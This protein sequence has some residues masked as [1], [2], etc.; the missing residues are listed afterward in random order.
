M[1]KTAINVTQAYEMIE[2]GEAVIVDVREPHEFEAGHIANAMSIP[3]S[4]FENAIKQVHV[5]ADKA[6]LF[7][8]QKGRRSDMA[9]DLTLSMGQIKNKII[10]VEGGM[11]DWIAANLPVIEAKAEKSIKPQSSTAMLSIDRQMRII[12]GL[13]IVALIAM[14]YLGMP[15]AFALVGISGFAY[16][17]SGITG[18]C[19]AER[20]L[21]RM[22]WNR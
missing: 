22:S 3:L 19:F 15:Y 9:C 6:I 11:N 17:L 10:N 20:L 2:K 1:S 13:V 5:P 18:I 16:F 4:N 7:Q 21:R 12:F 8:C 14:G